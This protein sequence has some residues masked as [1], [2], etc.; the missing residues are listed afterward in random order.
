MFHFDVEQ[1]NII[2]SADSSGDITRIDLRAKLDAACEGGSSSSAGVE[3]LF[4]N[5]LTSPTATRLGYARHKGAVKCLAQ[6]SALVGGS[7][8]LVGGQGFSVGLLDLRMVRPAKAAVTTSPSAESAGGGFTPSSF[9]RLWGPQYLSPIPT[10]SNFDI[11]NDLSRSKDKDW[12]LSAVNIDPRYRDTPNHVIDVSVSGLHYSKDGK[13]FAVSYQGD[14][15]YTFDSNAMPHH[16]S[17][18]VGATTCVGGHVN[19]DTFLKT[20]SFFGPNDEYIVSGSDSGFLW[21]WDSRSGSLVPNQLKLGKFEKAEKL[22]PENKDSAAMSVVAEVGEGN[23]DGELF[24]LETF[25]KKRNPCQV[26]N[27]LLAG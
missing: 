9:V 6:S 5:Y 22:P 11:P 26:L 27:C 20:V 21:I 15:I 18:G 14:Q 2:Y 23:G 17:R 4:S 13:R 25:W 24:P 3:V 10:Y 7:Q 12:L 16:N 8:L 19:H 1:P